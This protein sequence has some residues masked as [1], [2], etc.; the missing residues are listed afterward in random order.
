MGEDSVAVQFPLSIP[1]GVEKPYFGMGDASNPVNIWRWAS[2]TTE[3]PESAALM[4]ARGFADII[5]RDAAA[6][7]L[8]ATGIYTDGTWRVV[9]TR[10][11]TPADGAAD[12]RF[13]EGRFIPIAFA[14]WDGSN[15][16]RGSRHTLTIWYWLLLEPPGS[17]RPIIVA[18]VIIALFAAGEAWWQRSANKRR[19]HDA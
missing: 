7:G 5:P 10:P 8:Q 3:A 6:A 1:S 9:M 17:S 18:L 19:R 11:L 13:E 16:E 15:A 4:N 2:G 14:A 12:I